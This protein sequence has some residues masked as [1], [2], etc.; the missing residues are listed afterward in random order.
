[1]LGISEHASYTTIDF[2]ISFDKSLEI[3]KLQLN[4]RGESEGG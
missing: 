4:N 2:V 3:E 1:M